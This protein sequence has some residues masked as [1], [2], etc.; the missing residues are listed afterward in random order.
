MQRLGREFYL[1]YANFVARDLIGKILVHETASGII[2]EYAEECKDF[3]WRYY[4]ADNKF[5]STCKKK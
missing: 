3:L 1:R 5:V 4:A 2:V